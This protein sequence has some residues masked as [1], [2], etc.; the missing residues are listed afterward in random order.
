MGRLHQQAG[1]GRV[2]EWIREAAVGA[3]YLEE[4]NPGDGIELQRSVVGSN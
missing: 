2:K 1:V 4:V 3:V